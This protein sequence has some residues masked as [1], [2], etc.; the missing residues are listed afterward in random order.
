MENELLAIQMPSNCDTPPLSMKNVYKRIPFS[1]PLL[2]QDV[3]EGAEKLHEKDEKFIRSQF[4]IDH[5]QYRK[6]V[7]EP[8]KHYRSRYDSERVITEN[9]M[10]SSEI[11]NKKRELDKLVIENIRSCIMNDDHQ[12]VFTYLNLLHF[13]VSLKLVVKLCD[14]LKQTQLAQQVSKFLDD[15]QYRESFEAERMKHTN[16]S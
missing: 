11:T 8:L 14:Q 10:E 16:V 5:E 3:I 4:M 1:I 13:S 12:K 6:D 9:I 7:W 2:D 15:K